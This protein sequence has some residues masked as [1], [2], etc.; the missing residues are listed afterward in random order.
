MPTG[1]QRVGGFDIKVIEGQVVVQIGQFA[2]LNI[3]GKSPSLP[4]MLSSTPLAPLSGMFTS[5]VKLWGRFR[6][7]GAAA[8]TI[9]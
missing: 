6:V 3:E 8:A 4:P 2:V 1:G 5:A 9:P 7:L